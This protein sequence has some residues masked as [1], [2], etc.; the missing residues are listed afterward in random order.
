MLRFE[1]TLLYERRLLEQKQTTKPGIRE[2]KFFQGLCMATSHFRVTV[3]ICFFTQWFQLAK[4]YNCEIER[5]WLST[6]WSLLNVI[7]SF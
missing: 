6:S 5:V 1:Y 3:Y 4:S 7:P 2:A